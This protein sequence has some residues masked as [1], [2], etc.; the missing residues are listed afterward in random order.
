MSHPSDAEQQ[1]LVDIVNLEQLHSAIAEQQGGLSKRLKQVAAWLLE[2]PN[3]AAF[4]TLAEIA[5]AAGVH[6][7]TLVRFA[8]FFGFSGF[9]ELQ[10]LY[11][12]DLLENTGNYQQRIQNVR[13]LAEHSQDNHAAG[14]LQEFTSA[15]LMAMELLQ[16]Q[17]NPEQINAAVESME[18]AKNIHICGFRRVYSVAHYIHYALSQLDVPSHL[19][20]ATGGM[21]EEELQMLDESSLLIAITFKPYMPLTRQAVSIAAERGAKVLLI[22]DSELCPVANKADHLL[23]TREAEVRAFRS[24]NITFCL[25]QTLCVAL[26]YKRQG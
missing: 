17:A 10:R 7:S 4:N 5:E 18:A 15:N 2:H 3:Q 11:K 16:A 8:N 9:S 6:A 22:T 19:V 1:V 25:A 20:T 24:L 13:Q 12:Q 21:M 23:V 26:G 14:L